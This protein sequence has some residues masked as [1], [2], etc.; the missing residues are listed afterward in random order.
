VRGVSAPRAGALKRE[1]RFLQTLPRYLSALGPSANKV[2]TFRMVGKRQDR[3]RRDSTFAFR[4]SARRPSLVRWRAEPKLALEDCTRERRLRG[5][6]S[7]SSRSR[8]ARASDCCVACRAEARARGLHARAKAG[9]EEGIRTPTI[10]LSPAPQAGASASSATSARA[11]M[12]P[13]SQRTRRVT[14]RPTSIQYMADARRAA[15]RSGA[16]ITRQGPTSR[17]RCVCSTDPPDPI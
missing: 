4:A 14:R 5:W 11:C 2:V 10:L 17:S 13:S 6:P 15:T 12:F 3:P 7:R 8:M 16:P 1:C 9:A